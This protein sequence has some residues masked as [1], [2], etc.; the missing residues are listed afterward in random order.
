MEYQQTVEM[1]QAKILKLEQLVEI[2]DRKA[3]GTSALAPGASFPLHTRTHSHRAHSQAARQ[4]HQAMRHTAR[5]RVDSSVGFALM[6]CLS[7][8]FA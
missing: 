6:L 8:V 2:K 5:R 4:W 3:D 7:S 1:L